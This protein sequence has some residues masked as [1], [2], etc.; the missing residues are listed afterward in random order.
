MF[1]QSKYLQAIK[2]I[3]ATKSF[4]TI[5]EIWQIFIEKENVLNAALLN[6]Y[7]AAEGAR[8]PEEI[9][10]ALPEEDCSISNLANAINKVADTDD[11]DLIVETVWGCIYL[12][13]MNKLRGK[14]MTSK[15]MY[16]I[17]KARIEKEEQRAEKLISVMRKHG[18]IN[19]V[20]E[21]H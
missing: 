11:L 9:F 17:M 7:E 15:E 12:Y 14:T 4:F 6:A 13:H 20:N 5:D 18:L 8:A 16:K 21:L 10:E 2:E 19:S 3:R 1:D